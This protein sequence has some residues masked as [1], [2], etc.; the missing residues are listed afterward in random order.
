MNVYTQLKRMT[1]D[2]YFAYLKEEIDKF[3]N[4]PDAIEFT[5]DFRRMSYI[6]YDESEKVVT[7]E[8][9]AEFLESVDVL[10]AFGT[11][12][13]PLPYIQ[14]AVYKVN[15]KGKIATY[16]TIND[17]PLRHRPKMNY[18]GNNENEEF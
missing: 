11:G 14:F 6:S 10:P 9:I 18:T 2:A 12:S 13:Y 4:T 17:N 8:A 3:K 1:P 16:C 7:L 5:F 15:F